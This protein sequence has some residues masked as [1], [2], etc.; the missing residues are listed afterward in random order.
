MIVCCGEAPPPLAAILDKF[1]SPHTLRGSG[2]VVSV[3]FLMRLVK[4]MVEVMVE[5]MV[6]MMMM[7]MM[8]LYI[9]NL[10]NQNKAKQH[11]CSTRELLSI[12]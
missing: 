3:E 7:M 5:V 10:T 6:M 11:S 1:P 8:L 12:S 2:F 9:K 4:V